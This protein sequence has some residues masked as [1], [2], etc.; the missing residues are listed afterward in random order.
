MRL[1]SRKRVLR[2]DDVKKT[3]PTISAPF[4]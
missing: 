2:E 3:V 4:N 1:R